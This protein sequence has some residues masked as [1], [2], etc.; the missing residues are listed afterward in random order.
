[1]NR[2]TDK[3]SIHTQTKVQEGMMDKPS[4]TINDHHPRHDS[5]HDQQTISHT[6]R[7]A[8]QTQHCVGIGQEKHMNQRKPSPTI[9]SDKIPTNIGSSTSNKPPNKA[10]MI[11]GDQGITGVAGA[12][13]SHNLQATGYC[14]S[15]SKIEHVRDRLP[16]IADQNIHTPIVIHT[17]SND[18]NDE[19][20]LSMP[21][22]GS[23][24]QT[25]L[26]KTV[27]EIYINTIPEVGNEK[28]KD[29]ARRLNILIAHR[30]SKNSRLRA[31]NCNPNT[32]NMYLYPNPENMYL[33]RPTRL[34]QDG[35]DWFSEKLAENFT[36]EAVKV[37]Q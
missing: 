10:V 34:N 17:G 12:M 2:R 20:R 24:I 3:Q 35:L 37:R 11:I 36:K 22:I 26:D 13:R 8:M 15:Y 28:Q 21:A 23:L 29:R 9:M 7:A 4:T 16:E 25:A 18:L 1:M 30:C 6:Q 27:N 5:S 33:H 32:E 31:I 14:Y 19:L